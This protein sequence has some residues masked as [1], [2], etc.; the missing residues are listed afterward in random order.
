MLAS[1]MPYFL[2]S[3]LALSPFDGRE[4]AFADAAAVSDV[5][6]Q[7]FEWR[8]PDVAREC[9]DFLGPKGYTAVQV[10]PPTEHIKGDQWYTRYQPVSYRLVSRSGWEEQF[11][12]AIARCKKAGVKVYADVVI[13]HMA[14]GAGKGIAE[15]PYDSRTRK[16][17]DHAPQ[18]FHLLPGQPLTNCNITMF[19][20]KT[21]EQLQ[22]CDILK[23][24]DLCTGCQAVRKTLGNFFKHLMDI[25]VGGL[26]VDAAK[27]IDAHELKVLLRDVKRRNVEITQEVFAENQQQNVTPD[28][29]VDVGLVENFEYS[30]NISKR[31]KLG[32]GMHELPDLITNYTK[33]VPS[34]KA[35]VFIDNHDMQRNE[36]ALLTYKDGPSYWMA[37]IFMLA[38][39]Y[40]IPKV[41]SSY[42]LVTNYTWYGPPST[43]VHKHDRV[44]CGGGFTW[45]CE[46]R[47]P[48]IANMVAWRRSAGT[49]P[50]VH[51]AA[52]GGGRI[53]FGRGAAAFVAMNQEVSRSGGH[54]VA[55]LQTGLPAGVYCDVSRSD[56]PH[57][58]PQLN[59]RVGGEI[60]I[61]LPPNSSLALHIGCLAA[62]RA[63]PSP[64]PSSVKPSTKG[65]P[66][67]VFG[68]IM[69][70]AFG[71]FFGHVLTKLRTRSTGKRRSDDAFLTS[72]LIETPP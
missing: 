71:C 58:C 34:D 47:I 57:V 30:G 29:Y 13:N 1:R 23:L 56:E 49:S 14:K 6:A 18:D 42:Y 65:S 54:W 31:I 38:W 32:M 45:V 52:D 69:A 48:A 12:E 25:G 36:K 2:F 7:L 39:P 8:W 67:L 21:R 33:V 70:L 5:I 10:S 60:E 62:V 55:K 27:H 66:P 51:W 41:M 61:A 46:H 11:V 15:S 63:T 20:D 19:D 37:N 72:N 3:I 40:G 9:E 26:R 53:A 24:P 35:V 22:T 28:M 68:V 17:P 50:V 59:V 44:D 64:S 16:Y 43:P 4:L